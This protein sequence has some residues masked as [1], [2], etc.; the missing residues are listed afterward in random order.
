VRTPR[1]ALASVAAGGALVMGTVLALPA[2]ADPNLP[3]QEHPGYTCTAHNEGAVGLH[4]GVAV[5]DLAALRARVNLNTPCA[6]VAGLLVQA[7]LGVRTAHKTVVSDQQALNKA[8]QDVREA[9]KADDVAAATRDKAISDAQKAYLA[10]KPYQGVHPATKIGSETQAQADARVDA[11]AD[12]LA[13]GTRD[14]K[15]MAAKKAYSDG[16]TATT[17][18]NAKAAERAAEAQCA[19]DRSAETVAAGL[20]VTLRTNLINCR[21]PVPTPAPTT[22]PAPVVVAPQPP[23]VFINPAQPSVIVNNPQVG[24]IPQGPA[25]TGAVD[26]A[27][28][29]LG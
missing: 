14:Q 25:P 21:I 28:R 22:E 17:L 1:L 9:Q 20:V 18:A 27:D 7:Q 10:G 2:A 15:I 24:V 19:A 8:R 3:C 26:S 6:D 16:G 11:A 23:D 4:V 29:Y 5:N 13:L 12:A